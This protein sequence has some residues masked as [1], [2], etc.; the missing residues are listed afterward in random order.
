MNNQRLLFGICGSF[1]NHTKIVT[2]LKALA[3][4]ND[5]QVIVSKNVYEMDTR[6]HK[7][8]DFI[9]EIE[10]IT[11]HKVMH[12]LQEAEKSGPILQFD[13]MI[14]AP[15]SATVCAKIVHGIYDHPITLAIKAM[16]RNKKNIVFGIAT[17]DGLGISG[18]NIFTLLNYRNFYIIPF[19][20]DAPFKKERS[21]VSD[22]S[23]LVETCEKAQYNEQL[24]P[25][26]LGANI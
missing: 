24:E 18:A 6:Y 8:K 25:I 14:V 9:K 10:Q 22:W 20:Q 1:C 11:K 26:L 16:L 5:V 13:M 17:N 23:L 2:E 19:R 15:M 4:N 12:T 21:I 7:A 3:Q